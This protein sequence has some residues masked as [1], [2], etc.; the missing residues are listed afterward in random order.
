VSISSTLYARIFHTNIVFSS[1]IVS[2]RNDVFMKNSYIERWWNWRQVS[3]LSTFYSHILQ[4]QIPKAQKWQS[5]Y[6]WHFALLGSMR[7]KAACKTLMKLTP[8]WKNIWM[9]LKFASNFSP[10]FL[11]KEKIFFFAFSGKL[12]FF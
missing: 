10:S 8:A 5:S 7:V 11:I 6:Q 3:I 1:Y 9:P 2:C 12:F 4:K